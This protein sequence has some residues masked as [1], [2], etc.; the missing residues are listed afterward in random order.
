MKR[1]ATILMLLIALI[2]GT[3]NT[4]AYTYE[5]YDMTGSIGKYQI[6][7]YIEINDSTGKATGWYYYK[8]KGAKNKIQLSGTAKKY[9]IYDYKVVLTEKVNG[10]V[11]GTF[12]GDFGIAPNGNMSYYGTWTSPNGKSLRFELDDIWR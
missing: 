9:G 12:S 11:T 1:I 5:T 7:I 2:I 6:K 3:E 8:S 10:K 4:Q